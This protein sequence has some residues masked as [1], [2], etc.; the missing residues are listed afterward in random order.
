MQFS[1]VKENSNALIALQR[2]FLL[3]PSERPEEASGR[4]PVFEEVFKH[5]SKHQ[6]QR[7]HVRTDVRTTQR[8]PRPESSCSM[9]SLNSKLKAVNN[10]DSMQLSGRT[11]WRLLK[12]VC[13]LKSVV[14][15]RPLSQSGRRLGKFEF[16]LN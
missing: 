13:Y 3:W 10:E 7:T 9:R 2:Q 16:V 4:P 1:K 14:A 6:S 8:T 5:F 12:K 15:W 11:H